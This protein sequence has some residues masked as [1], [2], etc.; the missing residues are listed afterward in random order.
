[1]TCSRTLRVF[2]GTLGLLTGLNAFAFG[3]GV[4]GYSGQGGTSCLSSSCHNPNGAAAPTTTLSGPTTLDAGQIATYTLMIMGGPAAVAGLDVSVTNGSG[5]TLATADGTTQVKSGEITQTSPLAF[6]G[7]SASFTFQVTAPTTGGTFT[8]YG[9][10]LSCNNDSSSSGDN[11]NQTTL[12]ITVNGG[13]P[14][15]TPDAGPGSGD[16]GPGTSSATVSLLSP[17][18][19][20][21]I[22]GE[23]SLQ[24]LAQG[25][26]GIANVTFLL[27]TLPLGTLTQPAYSLTFDTRLWPN[28]TYSLGATATDPMGM[29]VTTPPVQVTIANSGSSASSCS[30]TGFTGGMLAAVLALAPLARRRRRTP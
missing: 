13:G 26:M 4:S 30:T 19:G 12:L 11:E 3:S 22:S 5:A 10:G 18:Q 16:G 29:Q 25:P 8:L 6:T 28:G 24:A 15:G 23:V 21:T 2:A 14:I 20:Q 1:L 17:T 27:N 9:N 7:T